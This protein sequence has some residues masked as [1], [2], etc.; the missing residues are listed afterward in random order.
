MA[1]KTGG[2]ESIHCLVTETARFYLEDHLTCNYLF[3]SPENSN[4]SKSPGLSPYVLLYIYIYIFIYIYVY[5]YLCFFTVN[6]Y[7]YVC[8]YTYI[9]INIYIYIQKHIYIYMRT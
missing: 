5:I 6:V 1:L 2:P 7:I 3:N 4:V 8:T 9:H